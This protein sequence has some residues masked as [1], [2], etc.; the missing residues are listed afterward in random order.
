VGSLDEI[1]GL[2]SQAVHDAG[3]WR[4][5]RRV[6]AAEG[7]RLVVEGKPLVSFASNDYLG[8]A[9]HPSLKEAAIRAVERW[10]TGSAAS[11]LVSGSLAAH[12][13]LEEALAAW[14]GTQAALSFSSGF[15]TA[16]G[17]I[18]ALVGADDFVILDKLVHAC[19]V[20][21]IRL[22]GAKMR[23]YRHNDL[24][25]FEAKLRWAVGQRDAVGQR[26][27]GRAPRILVVTES[28]FSMDGDLAPLRE[29]VELKDRYGAWLMLDEAHAVG[30]FGERR[31]GLAEA[32]EL[33]NRVDIHMGTLG[34]ALGC[35]G[36]YVVGSR[37]LVDWLV[38]RAR[39][40]VFSTAPTPAQAEV[41]RAAV[42]LVSGAEG[43]QRAHRLWAL[44]DLAKNEFTRA[45]W[46]PGL[47]RS[48]ILPLVIGGESEA[49]AVS[50][51]L[52]DAGWFVPAIRYPT[53]AKGS[54]RLR[55]TLSANHSADD[56]RALANALG[57]LREM[58][59]ELAQA[60]ASGD[61]K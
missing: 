39:S 25:D 49:M 38:N 20:D 59:L 57:V 17:V 37:V 10:G 40:F 14:K 5:L 56:V 54:A 12:H 48:A 6:D 27:G 18:P 33:A 1:L 30:L 9:G 32:F 13:E 50:A 26:A 7:V 47:V 21:A 28:V 55:V 24:E 23:V 43:A 4:T 60:S 45:G 52:R 41:A 31:T 34:K 36:G 61:P 42:E 58:K 53:V 15:A 11:R 44:V 51:S 35:A 16:L 2:E 22:S 8:L 19:C 46:S 3:L 29:L